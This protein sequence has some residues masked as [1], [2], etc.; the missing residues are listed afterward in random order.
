MLLRQCGNVEKGSCGS[1]RC[2]GSVE[3]Q[4]RLLRERALLRQCR[5]IEKGSCG[6][7]HCSGSGEEFL[8]TDQQRNVNQTSDPNQSAE[9]QT[10]NFPLQSDIDTAETSH[11]VYAQIDIMDKKK[12]N[13]KEKSSESGDTFYSELKHNTDRGADAGDATCAQPVRKKNKTH[14]QRNVN[15]TSDPNQSAEFQ[16]ENFPLQSADCDHIYDAVTEVNKRHKD[17]PETF[18]EI[19]YSEVTVQKKIPVDKDDPESYSEITYSEVTAK[20][21]L[22]YLSMKVP[23]CSEDNR[24][25]KE[26]HTSRHSNAGIA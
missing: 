11:L 1:G 20:K 16:M 5:S 22:T 15:Q 21:Y 25:L 18:S 4:E 6:S 10:E 23:E 24:R 14:Q 9:S 19:T 13:G 17:D 2:C 12:T 8:K 26:I 3:I 7:R